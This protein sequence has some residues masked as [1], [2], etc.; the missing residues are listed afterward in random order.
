MSDIIV[1]GLD[2][3]TGKTTSKEMPKEGGYGGSDGKSA[4]EVAVVNGFVGTEQE[5]LDSLVGPQGEQGATGAAGPQGAT[6]PQGPAGTD[7]QDGAQGLQ[8][9]QGVKGDK[10]DK[11]DTGD[12]GPQG[13]QGPQ[14][15]QGE[16]G[17][18][19]IQGETG[20]TGPQGIA[21]QDGA[22]ADITQA[23]PIGSVFMAVVNTNPASLLGFGTWSA[24]GAGKMLVG[25]DANDTDF[26]TAEETGG[27]KTHTLTEAQIPAHTHIQD[28]HTHIQNSHNHTQDSHNHTQNSFAPR[29]INSGTAGTVGVQGASAA[30]NNNASNSATTATNQAATATNQAATATNQNTTAVNQNTGGGAAHNN[31]PPYIVVYMWKRTA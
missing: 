19:G 21:G 1:Y 27:A 17:L 3:E 4:Y 8:G 5:W 26:D 24:F 29:I 20:Q 7:G 11:G 23:W 10:G 14:G 30:S 9:I 25:R 22:D 15:E 31:M 2:P 6:G 13:I 16:Q 12:Q 18:Q 28:A